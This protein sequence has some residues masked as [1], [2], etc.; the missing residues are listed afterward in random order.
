MILTVVNKQVSYCKRNQYWSCQCKSR[1][2]GLSAFRKY[3]S[4]KE[5]ITVRRCGQ[6]SIPRHCSYVIL[7]KHTMGGHHLLEMLG[8]KKLEYSSLKMY[9]NYVWCIPII[10]SCGKACLYKVCSTFVDNNKFSSLLLVIQ[11][12][13]VKFYRLP[14]SSLKK[15]S[16]EKEHPFSSLFFFFVQ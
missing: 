10:S 15:S 1:Q 11:C 16:E 7:R 3:H 9:S 13:S 6:D 2:T 12:T 4:D 8:E 14:V 5:P